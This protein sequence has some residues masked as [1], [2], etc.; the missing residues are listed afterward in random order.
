[1][2]V[3][4]DLYPYKACDSDSYE[5]LVHRSIS[6]KEKVNRISTGVLFIPLSLVITNN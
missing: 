6:L 2:P 4:I 5:V 1:M 3:N